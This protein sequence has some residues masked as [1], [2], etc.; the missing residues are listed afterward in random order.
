[1]TIKGRVAITGRPGVGKTTLIERVLKRLADR[2]DGSVGGMI[3][4]ETRVC[5]RRV[6]F[7][8]R[9]VATGREGVLAHIHGKAGPKIGRYTVDVPSLESVGIA[10]VNRAIRTQELVVIDEIAPMELTSE[11][12]APVVEAALDSDRGLLI[13]T[14]ANANHPLAH[15]VRQELRLFRVKLGNRDRL[16]EEIV[17]ALADVGE[18]TSD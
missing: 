15:R 10:A 6:G 14:H 9:D 4:L 7:A 17:E 3:T 2:R 13:S 8:V 1:M 11:A 18:S 5:G 16:V 12:F